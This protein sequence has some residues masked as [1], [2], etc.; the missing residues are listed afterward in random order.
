MF[1]LD[2]FYNVL[3]SLGRS[4]VPPEGKFCPAECLTP[5]LWCFVQ[6]CITRAPRSC[7]WG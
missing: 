1:L 4:F 5:G 3:A 7:S 6:A 2:W